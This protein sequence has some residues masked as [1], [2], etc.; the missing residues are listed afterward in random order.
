MFLAP[1]EYLSFTYFS[2]QFIKK[3]KKKKKN[4]EYRSMLN[5]EHQQDKLSLDS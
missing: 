1:R 4:C 2:L 5:E 3:K